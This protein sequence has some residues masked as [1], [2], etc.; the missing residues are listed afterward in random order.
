MRFRE[1]LVAGAAVACLTGSGA[2]QRAG[3]PK[4]GVDGLLLFRDPGSV[5]ILARA[6]PNW[7]AVSTRSEGL[8]GDFQYMPE[9]ATAGAQ[10]QVFEILDS[11]AMEW[12]GGSRGG[13]G[14]PGRFTAVPWAFGPGCAGEAWQ[15]PEWVAPGDTVAFLL[16]PTRVRSPEADGLPVFDVLGWQQPYPVGELIPFWR[17]GPREN[18]VWL[19]AREFYELL[20]VL[21]LELAFRSDPD[22]A[23]APA[24]DWMARRPE[25]ESAF[26]VPELLGEWGRRRGELGHGTRG[27]G[28]GMRPNGG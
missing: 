5:A 20:T 13:A 8:L 25:R 28:S 18:P 6:T 23:L 16:V 4:L 17:K 22:R 14:S 10:G 19:T 12:M 24:L 21:P 11:D 9:Y 2:A 15:A 3:A 1:I 26:P 7:Q 27:S